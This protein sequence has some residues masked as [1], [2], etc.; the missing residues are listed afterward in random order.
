MSNEAI[1]KWLGMQSDKC[2]FWVS[3]SRF[4]KSIKMIINLWWNRLPNIILVWKLYHHHFSTGNKLLMQNQTLKCF[5]CHFY[6]S[7]FLRL[8]Q[9]TEVLGWQSIK[10]NKSFIFCLNDFKLNNFLLHPSKFSISNNS[11]S[12][13]CRSYNHYSDSV[14]VLYLKVWGYK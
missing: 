5:L 14:S 13:H 8:I 12:L 1:G 6:N 4:Q 2:K 10:S 9:W 11:T 3:I 7:S